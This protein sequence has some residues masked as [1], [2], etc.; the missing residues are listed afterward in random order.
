MVLFDVCI[1]VILLIHA[2]TFLPKLKDKVLLNSVKGALQDPMFPHRLDFT[3]WLAE[4]ITDLQTWG[5][6]CTCP[7]HIE[8]HE[9]GIPVECQHKGRLL[10][11]AYNHAKEHL[12]AG[13]ALA[14]EW[15]GGAVWK[16]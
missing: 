5:G 8:A 12:E 15:G 7:E 3:L 1:D 10:H 2:I 9:Q 4:W 14:E 11:V 16:G 13:V 6:S